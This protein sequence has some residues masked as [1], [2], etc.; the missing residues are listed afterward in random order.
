MAE[1][2][3]GC[4]ALSVAAQNPDL[5][6]VLVIANPATCFESSPLQPFIPLMQWVPDQLFQVT[7]YLLSFTMGSPDSRLKL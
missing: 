7:P 4:L 1:S 5:D 2:F 3:G 6:I